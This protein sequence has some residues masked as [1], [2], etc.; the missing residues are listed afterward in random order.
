MEYKFR[1]WSITPTVN[2]AQIVNVYQPNVYQPDLY[3]YMYMYMYMYVHTMTCI[4]I[5]RLKGTSSVTRWKQGRI[6]VFVTLLVTLTVV[7]CFVVDLETAGVLTVGR[8]L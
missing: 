4:I 6:L 2:Q 8:I 5:N 3:M 1:V 7:S